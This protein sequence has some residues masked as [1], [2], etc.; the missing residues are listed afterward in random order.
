[1]MAVLMSQ[2]TSTVGSMRVVSTGCEETCGSHVSLKT[3]HRSSHFGRIRRLRCAHI[4]TKRILRLESSASALSLQGGL[5]LEGRAGSDDAGSPRRQDIRVLD[6]FD[7][8]FPAPEDKRVLVL[9]LL[10]NVLSVMTYVVVAPCLGH[11]IDVISATPG[12][13]Y[14]QLAR[15]VG[16]LALAYVMSNATLAAQVQLASSVGERL[17]KSVRGRLFQSIM[18][19]NIDGRRKR[20]R[21][22]AGGKATADTHTA[23]TVLTG[24]R[25]S[26]LTNDIQVLQATV[27]KLLGARGI[28][29]GLE[30]IAILG[31]LLYLHWVLA[32]ILL[33]SAPVL[34]PLVLSAANSIKILSE[35]VQEAVGG[36]AAAAVE[37]LENQ[38]VIKVL[39]AEDGQVHRYNGLVDVQSTANTKLIVFQSLLDVSGRL[40]NVFCVLLTVG[41]GAHLALMNQ[42]T[43]GTCYSFFIYG[44]GFA[45]A[46]SNVAQSVGDMYKAIGAL[47]QCYGVLRPKDVVDDT[48][49]VDNLDSDA[50]AVVEDNGDDS[51][52]RFDEQLDVDSVEIEFRNVSFSHPDGWTMKDISFTIPA[53]TTTALVGPSGGG[54]ST[55][56]SLLLG[57]HTPTSGDIYVNGVPLSSIDMHAW[58]KAVGVVEQKPGLLVGTVEDV[59]TYG[60]DDST[61]KES[62]HAIALQALQAAQALEFVERLPN[63]MDQFIDSN[64]LSGGQSQRL[65]LARALARQPKLLVLDEATSALDTETERKLKFDFLSIDGSNET[66]NTTTLVIAHRL[67]TVRDCENIVV[68]KGGAIVA[69]GSGERF[70]STLKEFFFSSEDDSSTE[71]GP[72]GCHR[73]DDEESEW[74]SD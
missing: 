13:S 29:S 24:S 3:S 14:G 50:V 18:D 23:S 10:T 26:W 7:T 60:V 59:V 36:T 28:R 2:R 61:G 21:S 72:D 49:P 20:R 37:M 1:M 6:L 32:L 4:D 48:N 38:K 43:V 70:F 30:T 33:V 62:K 55:I 64:S 44:F 47:K 66:K 65:A 40:R 73:A 46:L 69:Q 45:F 19:T 17:A 5:G 42:V 39:G 34:T 53:G 41:L 8:L 52:A 25:L 11:V 57:F 51:T 16:M 12:S 74:Y 54:K 67:T 68:V 31:V 56:A 63:G 15:A 9:C 27:T 22:A 71:E 35:D 58:R